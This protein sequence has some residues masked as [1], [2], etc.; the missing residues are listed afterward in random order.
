MRPCWGTEKKTVEKN[1]QMGKDLIQGVARE[2][3]NTNWRSERENGRVA[4]GGTR[5]SI[6]K[7]LGLRREQ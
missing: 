5:D 4:S 1:E 2:L 6:S 3:K 7:V